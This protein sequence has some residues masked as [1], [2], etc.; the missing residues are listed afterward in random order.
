MR[1][2]ILLLLILTMSILL[3]SP[4][5]YAEGDPDF[6][7]Y[8]YTASDTTHNLPDDLD[9]TKTTIYLGGLKIYENG[10]AIT[11]NPYITD[12]RDSEDALLIDDDVLAFQIIFTTSSNQQPNVIS[13]EL[14]KDIVFIVADD[15]D[16]FNAWGYQTS[17]ES[18]DITSL[19]PDLTDIYLDGILHVD[20]G[21]Y[22]GGPL[23]YFTYFIDDENSLFHLTDESEDT[24]SFTVLGGITNDINKS[25]VIIE[26]SAPEPPYQP[27][28]THYRYYSAST[29]HD[30]TEDLDLSK[31]TFFHNG[32]KIFENGVELVPYVDDYT[33]GYI[34]SDERL[35][36][37][38]PLPIINIQHWPSE[39]Y[40]SFNLETGSMI[41]NPGGSVDVVIAED[42]LYSVEI[43]YLSTMVIDDDYIEVEGLYQLADI[44]ELIIDFTNDFILNSELND[45]FDISHANFDETKMSIVNDKIVYDH[46]VQGVIDLIWVTPG[47]L[48]LSGLLLDESWGFD[49]LFE[50]PLML[51]IIHVYRVPGIT[52]SAVFVTNVDNPIT[53]SVISASLRAFDETD[54]DITNQ[55]V[56]TLDDFT[57]N[58]FVVGE[59]DIVYEVTDSAENTVT[60]T[61]TVFV[62]D[63]EKPVFTFIDHTN[64]GTI[65][66]IEVSYTEVINLN[67][68]HSNFTVTDNYD[69]FEDLTF[70]IYDNGGYD[71]NSD[72]PGAYFVVYRVEDTSGNYDFGELIIVVIDDV[73]PEIFGPDE[74]TTTIS[75]YLTLGTI[76]M[77]YTA[78]DE[79][80]GVLTHD[81]SVI[82][83]TFTA[84]KDQAGTYQITIEVEDES[85]NSTQKVITVTVTDD[86]VPVFYVTRAFISVAESIT[87]TF[88]D[89]IRILYVTGQIDSVEGYT[90]M[91]SN[92]FGNELNPGVY[93]VSVSN[94]VQLVSLSI[95]VDSL[96]P[97]FFAVQ[98]NTYGGSFVQNLLISR[99]DLATR[100]ND[101]VRE[102]YTFG[103]WYKDSLFVNPMNW[104]DEVTNDMMLYA[105]WIPTEAPVQSNLPIILMYVAIGLIVIGGFIAIRKKAR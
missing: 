93:S 102:G 15:P 14:S 55:I 5:A 33:L 80:D 7:V 85:G 11:T 86:V 13:N 75:S 19:N 3:F 25:S 105:K 34:I 10:V 17:D 60:F 22:I 51:S 9:L 97:V 24:I 54:G 73:D 50:D 94:G 58:R 44:L 79:I 21:N 89:I 1:K 48:H 23:G 18:H 52:G 43:V 59:W 20:D 38:D 61:V 103:G 72:I 40:I 81:I 67:T 84:N 77:Q 95:N 39:E 82:S 42:P 62:R 83:E 27:G 28:F 100:P 6:T 65:D 76:L 88:D 31:V 4:S 57:P 71:E 70:T 98:F 47:K 64:P 90:L 96:A 87:L 53:E 49:D 101:P 69:D 32:E 16:S 45:S 37:T 2:L 78:E 104:D 74:F 63:I 41:N 91:S 12:V 56:K 92:Y 66:E 30:L 26:A 68:Y 29:T 99:G 46:P 8:A 35:S 36:P